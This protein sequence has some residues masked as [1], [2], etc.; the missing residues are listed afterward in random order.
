MADI[1]WV[2]RMFAASDL[3]QHISWKKFIRK[4]YYVV[5]PPPEKLRA[6]VAFRWFYEGR[7]KDV[8]EPHPLPCEYRGDYLE[9]LQTPSGKF[10]FEC[11]TL[12]RLDPPDDERPPV[13][14]FVR[15]SEDVGGDASAT[16]RCN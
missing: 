10:E 5:P 2:Q 6:P 12:K 1:D 15:S 3:P 16:I 13:L 8:P 4:G 7:K 9:G 14:Q 11:T